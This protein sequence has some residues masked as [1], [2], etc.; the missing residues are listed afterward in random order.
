MYSICTVTYCLLGGVWWL[1]C[2]MKYDVGVRLGGVWWLL[3][4]MK[5]DV[6]V[7]ICTVYV[8]S[9][10]ASWW[11]VVATLS[12]EARCRSQ[13]MYSICTVTSCLLVVCGGYSVT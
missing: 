12:H 8:L 1:L 13:Y 10:P 9:H 5:H 11:C 4:H 3:C 2:H 7:S 6:G